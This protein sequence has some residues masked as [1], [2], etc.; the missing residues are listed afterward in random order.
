MTQGKLESVKTGESSDSSDED[1]DDE[2]D[3]KPSGDAVQGAT[4]ET[5]KFMIECRRSAT[6]TTRARLYS[7]IVGLI[8]LPIDSCLEFDSSPHSPTPAPRPAH[9]SY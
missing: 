6:P 2:D 8:N 3:D 9:R 1:S 4:A 7:L 5:F